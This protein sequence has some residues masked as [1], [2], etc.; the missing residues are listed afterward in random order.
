M[1][2]R[3]P[4]LCQDPPATPAIT[5]VKKLA[6]SPN[7]NSIP[8]NYAYYT[9]PTET[10]ASDP[11]DPIPTVDLSL[12]T[13]DDADQKSKA[14]QELGRACQEWG[15]FMVVNHGIPEALMKAMLEAIDEFFNLPE[16]E[17]PEFQPKNVLE[18]IRYG[19]SFNTAKEKVFFWRDFL[20]VYV[21]P[22]FHCPDKPQSL[23][24]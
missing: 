16:E 21:H 22:A 9:N 15:F 19:T 6:E 17:K 11:D 14:I 8:S 20:K 10:T 23:R 4:L 12:L 24:E 2:A 13:S 18:P 3:T 7:L 5:C 1:A